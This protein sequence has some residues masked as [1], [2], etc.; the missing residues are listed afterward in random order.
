MQRHTRREFLADIGKGMIVASVGISMASE[1]G[2]AAG[3]E[4]LPARLDFGPLRDSSG[5]CR[6][7]RLRN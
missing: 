3:Q 4:D 1:L 2:I 6:R 5:S 7:R